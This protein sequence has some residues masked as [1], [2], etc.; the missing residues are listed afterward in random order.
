MPYAIGQMV[1]TIFGM[2]IVLMVHAG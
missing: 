2:I 1:L